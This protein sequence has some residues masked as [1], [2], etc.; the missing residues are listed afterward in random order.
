MDT[1]YKKRAFW[2]FTSQKSNTFVEKIQNV[3]GIASRDMNP[4]PADQKSIM[5]T[6]EASYKKGRIFDVESYNVLLFCEVKLKYTSLEWI[7]LSWFLGQKRP[8]L[9]GNENNF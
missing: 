2:I 1:A 8:N 7:L 6:I 4:W 3:I 5:L 9:A